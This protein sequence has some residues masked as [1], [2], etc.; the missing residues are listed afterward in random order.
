MQEVGIIGC[1]WVSHFYGESSR[2]FSDRCKIAWV[3]EPDPVKAEEFT[4]RYGG[5]VVS[6]Y[7]GEQADGIVIATPHHLH[8]RNC[9]DAM[10]HCRVL[11]VEKPLALTLHECDTVI[12]ARDRVGTRVLL[13]YVNR[14]R[15]GPQ[16]MKETLQSGLIGEPLLCD[17]SQFGC[18]E[19]YIG[20]WLLKRATLGGG[21]FFSSA[22]HILDLGLWM[23]GPIERLRVE[24][25]RRRLH[26][27]EGED[28]AL[29]LARFQSGV[30]GT[31]RESWCAKAPRSWQTF[32][33]FGS[34]GTLDWSYNPRRPVPEWHTCLWDG[35]LVLRREGQPPESLFQ[36]SAPFDFTGQ[37]EHFLACLE[38]DIS[39]SCTAEDG[40]RIVELVR[41]AEAQESAIDQT[42]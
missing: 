10:P 6:E 33:V 1:G 26:Q 41:D 21:C 22:G 15:K 31:F 18:Q 23:L 4:A 32:T 16:R 30:I 12:A 35:E 3:V 2:E 19:S 42:R 27:M 13:G 28:T 11:L 40:R 14:F 5:K 24:L 7:N 8:H 38:S 25:A 36:E 17:A 39:P 9:L 37:F 20:G 34:A 29:A